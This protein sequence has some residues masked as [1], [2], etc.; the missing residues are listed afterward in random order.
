LCLVVTSIRRDE[1]SPLCR[2]KTL[3]YLPSVLAA[4]EALDLGADDALMLNR[5]GKV[6]EA[7][8]SNIFLVLNGRLVTPDLQS[9]VL[10]GVTR[11]VVI[12]LARAIGIPVEERPVSV[13]EL[14]KAEEIF[15][16]NSIAGLRAVERLNDRPVGRGD[17]SL[18]ARLA[19]DYE[20]LFAAE[21]T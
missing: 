9:G 15:L 11:A 7:T 1:T 12:E 5:S 4:A 19:E 20:R 16:T 10:P 8:S 3:N 17:C 21:T 6:A 2:A 13:S 18:T 14:A